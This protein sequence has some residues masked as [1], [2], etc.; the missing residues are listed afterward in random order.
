MSDDDYLFDKSGT[1][2][3]DVA[4][5]ERLLGSAKYVSPGKNRMD[6]VHNARDMSAPAVSPKPARRHR[7]VAVVAPAVA[8]AAAVALVV[9]LRGTN[10]ASAAGL[11]VTR[12]QG[13][14][15]VDSTPFMDDGRVGISSTLETDSGGQAILE[16]D[17]IG[18]VSVFAST[19]LSVVSIGPNEQHLRL[20]SGAIYAH[21]TA[22][23]R[24]FV[25]DTPS[26]RAVDL[27]CEY[28][29]E[30]LPDGGTLLDVRTGAVELG[31]E[32]HQSLV[33][34][35]AKCETRPKRGPG[36]PY[37]DDASA[38]FKSAL[39]HLDFDAEP[40][41]NELDTLL[42]GARVRDTL[43]LWQ[44]IWRVD[45]ERRNRLLARVIELVPPPPGI[46]LTTGSPDAFQRY[47]DHLMTVWGPTSAWGQE[48]PVPSMPLP[49]HG[50]PSP[51]K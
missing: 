22:V 26:A 14:A 13:V 18:T 33:P 43:T 23:P 9:G 42:S 12:M 35:G 6:R 49:N 41:P 50:K 32:G 51:K 37:F 15:R 40:D 7:L 29:L 2:E 38:R 44:L 10:P 1:P 34:A 39:H 5:L 4:E 8:V 31:G 21:V 28:R 45:G 48:K 47:Q 30:V 27:G 11:K 17:K 19:R 20:H 16:L 25:V 3:P 46:D 36:T 24:V